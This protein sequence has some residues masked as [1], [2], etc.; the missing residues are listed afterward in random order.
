MVG[1]VLTVSTVPIFNIPEGVSLSK[2]LVLVRRH[3]AKFY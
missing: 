3:L 1:S 2:I